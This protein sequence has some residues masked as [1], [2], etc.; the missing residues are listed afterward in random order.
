MHLRKAFTLIELLVVIAIIAILA[1]ILFP[2]FAQAKVA[3]KKASD[4]SNLKQIGTAQMMYATDYDDVYNPNMLHLNCTDSNNSAAGADWNWSDGLVGKVTPWVG[5]IMPYVKNRDLFYSPA[6]KANLADSFGPNWYCRANLPL[7]NSEYYVSYVQNS[8]DIWWPDTTWTDGSDNHYGF[9]YSKWG[10][11][12][13]TVSSTSVA[14]IAGTIR[15]VDGIYTDIG[16]EAYTDYAAFSKLPSWQNGCGSGVPCTYIGK[17]ASTSD[18]NKAGFFADKVNILWAD[19][20]AGTKRWG[21]TRPDQW[22]IQD[23]KSMW[24]NSGIR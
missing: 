18:P 9:G 20:H 7:L 8:F 23:D 15:M 14:D 6:A 10:K 5:L 12:W 1:A 4:L 24:V 11:G 22:T 17:N 3:A 2:V 19:G 13:G 21:T 16:Y